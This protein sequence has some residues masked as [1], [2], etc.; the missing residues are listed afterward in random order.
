MA[1]IILAGRMLEAALFVGSHLW[2]FTM[3]SGVMA[4]PICF[5]KS[6]FKLSFD[7]GPLALR[8]FC[9][10]VFYFVL[11]FWFFSLVNSHQEK[12]IFKFW[13]VF[14]LSSPILRSLAEIWLPEDPRRG[15]AASKLTFS[16][17]ICQ[18]ITQA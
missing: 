6:G 16:C 12:K 11:F 1:A 9:L 4:S 7:S 17:G 8:F 3:T 15:H 14:F 18:F 2:S 13:M 10:C 5:D